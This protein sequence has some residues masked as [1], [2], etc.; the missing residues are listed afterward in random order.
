[1]RICVVLIALGVAVPRIA[2]PCSL[3][4]GVA[5]PELPADGS[6]VGPLPVLLLGREYGPQ[7]PLLDSAGD[8]VL[9]VAIEGGPLEGAT[10][11]FDERLYFFR[12]AAPL[13]PGDYTVGYQRFTVSAEAAANAELSSVDLHLVIERPLDSGGCSYG[14]SCDGVTITALELAFD[15]SVEPADNVL[16]QVSSS[17]GETRRLVRSAGYGEW[18]LSLW[19]DAERETCVTVTPVAADGKLGQPVSAGCVDP[20]DPDDPRVEDHRAA[21]GCSV[22][23]PRAAT[24][25]ALLALS[26]AGIGVVTRRRRRR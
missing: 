14:S 21:A 5:P 7:E 13:A 23:T 18:D 17:A 9:V 1:M 2:F 10:G 6:T 20:D 26:I 11:M 3:A 22:R 16:I 19:T 25:G 24:T 15:R 12:P 4:E 8:E